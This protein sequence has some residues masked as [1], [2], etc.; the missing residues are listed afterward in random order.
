M[1]FPTLGVEVGSSRPLRKITLDV[2]GAETAPPSAAVFERQR[3]SNGAFRLLINAPHDQP[4]LFRT[5]VHQLAEPLFVL[6]ILHTTRSGAAEGRYQSPPLGAE[7][8]DEFLAAFEPFLAGD[9]RH[10]VWAYSASDGRTVVWDRHDMIYVEG[11]PLTDIEAT[12]EAM[13]FERGAVFRTGARPH[14]HYY[15]AEFDD[16]AAAVLAHFEWTRSDLR[17]EDEQ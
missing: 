1:P 14:V 12:L 2:D 8:A 4:S 3:M 7:Q 17:P 10:D 11:E 13:A 5:L 16:D 15:R 6:Y 9:G